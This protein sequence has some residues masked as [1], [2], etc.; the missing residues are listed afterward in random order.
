MA[1]S[2]VSLLVGIA[3]DDGLITSV[4]DPVSKY[5]PEFY[6]KKYNITIRDLLTMGSGLAWNESYYNPFSVT[7]KAYYGNSL[8]KL[9]I[10]AKTT[11]PPAKRFEYITANPQLLSII[12]QKVTN[13]TLSEYASE[14]LWKPLGTKNDAS[15][16]LDR[17]NGVE[18]S[19]CCFNSNVRD[20]ARIGQLILNKG[21]WNGQQIVSEKYI[22]ESLMPAFYL[23]DKENEPVDFYGYQ[24]WISNYKSTIIYYARGI[25]GQYIIAIPEKNMV[26][27]RLGHKRSKEKINH[28][29][30]DLFGY[31]DLGLKIAN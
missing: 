29:P 8:N 21:S 31:I 30:K 11:E 1:K 24:W 13:K 9:V 26:I 4:N 16:S 23:V 10:D 5:I 19:F 3:I 12:L 6:N 17:K 18:K 27:V 7:T 15:W 22:K 28:H 25:L 2:F 14:K 20:F